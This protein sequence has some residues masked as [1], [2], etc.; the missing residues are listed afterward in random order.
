MP[1][2]H[3]AQQYQ[4]TEIKTATPVELVVLMYDSAIASLQ[5][6]QEHIAAREIEKRT[7][8]I[9]KA[10]AILTELQANL[11]FEASGGIAQSLDRLYRYMKGRIFLANTQQ[12][13]APLRETV[14][15]LSNLR[16]AWAEISQK[17]ERQ[18]VRP[19]N[20]IPSAAHADF[21]QPAGM[22]NRSQ[23]ASLNLTA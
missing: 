20:T 9:D 19:S 15:L 22:E 7:R 6:A 16:L 4:E 5:K 12:H 11:D 10:A 18:N 2:R 8:C 14:K 13:A 1:L 23:I 17:Q 21:P 3:Q